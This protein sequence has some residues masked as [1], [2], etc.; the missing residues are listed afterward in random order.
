MS[1]ASSTVRQSVVM[2]RDPKCTR[3]KMALKIDVRDNMVIVGTVERGDTVVEV[4]NLA[5]VLSI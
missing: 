2:G 4:K 5:W 1:V 3:C